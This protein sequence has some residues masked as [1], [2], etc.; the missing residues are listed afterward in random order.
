MTPTPADVTIKLFG[1]ME[2]TIGERQ[3]GAG[4]VGGIRPTQVLEILLAARGHP[5]PIDR[6]AD[7]RRGA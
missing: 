3:L 5:V 6:P 7:L 4:D 2:I 1:P